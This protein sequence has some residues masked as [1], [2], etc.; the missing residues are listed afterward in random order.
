M[1]GAIMMGM[2]KVFCGHKLGWSCCAFEENVMRTL[3]ALAL[4]LTMSTSAFGQ[5]SSPSMGKV[6]TLSTVPRNS[7]T[8]TE[9]YKQD[10]YDKSR[11][12]IGQIVDVLL[13]Q[14]GKTTGL[15]IEA[16]GF[17]GIGEHTVVVPMSAV[18]AT[19]TGDKTNLVIDITEDALRSAPAFIY[20][21]SARTWIRVGHPA[22]G[23]LPTGTPEPPPP[24]PPMGGPQAGGRPSAPGAP[25]GPSTRVRAVRALIEPGEMPPRDLAGYGLVAFTTLPVPHDIERYKLICEAYK[26]TLMSQRE[27]PPN[28]PLSEQ[29]ITF[30]PITNK[31]SPEAERT[32]CSYLVS[33]Y[34]LRLGLDAIQDADKRREGLASRRGP[35]LIAWVPSDSRF[36][37]DAV[38]LLMDLSSFEGQRSFVEVFQD[39]RQRI[40]DNP[41]LWR[42]GGF[43]IEA[44]RRIIR[45]IFDRY[46]EGLMRL[47]RS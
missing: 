43:D 21:P 24:P 27:L 32:D 10:V 40:T 25:V 28:T 18:R 2:S 12:K 46:G 19:K 7:V 20:D 14:D 22:T 1:A 34:A 5:Q 8:V 3:I 33:N 30:W 47:I 44:T 4:G 6:K 38:V 45:D 23:T 9:Y 39:W 17:L 26:A 31:S 42:R 41:E 36:K 13:S 35:F 11:Q 37:P 29:M 16:G 15:V